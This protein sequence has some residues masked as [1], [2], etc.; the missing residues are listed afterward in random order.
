[1]NPICYE[2]WDKHKDIPPEELCP[3]CGSNDIHSQPSPPMLRFNDK[4][5]E[6]GYYIGSDIYDQYRNPYC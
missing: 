6:D 5:S 3:F 2:M 1:M 4:V